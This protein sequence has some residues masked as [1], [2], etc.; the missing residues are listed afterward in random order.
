M[1]LLIHQTLNPHVDVRVKPERYT[2]IGRGLDEIMASSASTEVRSASIWLNSS[3]RWTMS[4][5]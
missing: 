3:S 4:M 5:S 1:R 2:V